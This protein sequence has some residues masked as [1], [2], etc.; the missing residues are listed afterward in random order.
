MR[1]MI[2]AMKTVVIPAP[3]AIVNQSDIVFSFLEQVGQGMGPVGQA[4]RQAC[5]CVFADRVTAWPRAVRSWVS[6]PTPALHP[7]AQ[8]P[9]CIGRVQTVFA[10]SSV[11]LRTGEP[12]TLRGS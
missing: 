3:I 6:S 8:R 4:G 11:Q 5:F 12:E 2:S 1:N 10:E 7:G 9:L